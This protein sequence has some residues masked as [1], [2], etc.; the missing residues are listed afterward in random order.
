MEESSS[1]HR[2][3]QM[4]HENTE[5]CKNRWSKA[6]AD[7]VTRN[8]EG[9]LCDLRQMWGKRGG[10]E[11]GVGWPEEGG[12]GQSEEASPLAFGSPFTL[13][14][15][16]WRAVCPRDGGQALPSPMPLLKMAVA[17]ETACQPA[18]YMAACDTSHSE[19]SAIWQHDSPGDM[20]C[21]W[22]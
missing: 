11:Q 12:K 2:Y 1:G 17:V 18:S 19:Q 21:K 22:V 5:N 10:K 7:E 3:A 9:C 15:L 8:V 16:D 20:C 6:I 13:V 14:C 4:L